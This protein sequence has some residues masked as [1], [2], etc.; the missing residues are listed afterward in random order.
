MLLRLTLKSWAQAVLLPQPL[1]W[2]DSRGVPPSPAPSSSADNLTCFNLFL[3]RKVGAFSRIC[4]PFVLP[5]DTC[6]FE[7]FVQLSSVLAFL[8]DLWVLFVH[9]GY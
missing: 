8:N 2:L 1:E 6:Q 9:Y 4:G 7:C 3:I 5:S